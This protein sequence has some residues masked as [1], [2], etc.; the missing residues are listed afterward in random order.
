M[1]KKILLI[2]LMVMLFT[3]LFV[4]SASAET[5]TYRGEEIEL[6]DNLGDPSWYTGDVATAI[7]DKTSIV[8]LKD[9]EGN[10]TAYPSYYIFNYDISKSNNVITS[11]SIKSYENKGVDYSFINENG[12]NYTDGSVYYVE[13]PYGITNLSANGIFGKDADAKPEPNVVEI[14]MPDSVTKIESQAFRRM[15]SCQKITFSRN[16]TSLPD[17]GFCGSTQLSTLIFPE[18][19]QLKTIGNSFNGC[20]SITSFDFTTIPNIETLGSCFSSTKLAGPVDLS[21]LTKL[22]EITGTFQSC[23]IT[24]VTLPDN[25]QVIGDNAF[26]N[27]S[28]MYFASD[29]LPKS[30]I[31]IGTDNGGG[32]FLKNCK[33][34]NS[35][36]YFPESLTSI[37]SNYNFEGVNTANGAPLNLVFLGKMTEI[38]FDGGAMSGWTSGKITF[39]FAKNFASELE[40]KF[41]ESFEDENGQK[42]YICCKPDKTSL[43]TLKENTGLKILLAN[44]NP[45][46]ETTYGT[47]ADGNILKKISNS[48]P[49]FVFC[50]GEV[51]QEVFWAR[52]GSTTLEYTVFYST[53][54]EFD[55]AAHT[56]ANKH[57]N[58]IQYQP[59]NC[60]YDECTTTTCIV[61]K[62][63][64][65]IETENKATGEHT[66]EDDFN[67]ESALLCTTCKKELVAALTHINKITVA[68]ANGYTNNGKKISAC[69]NEG[70]N[71]CTE[72]EV[73]PIF[74]FLGF[75]IKMDE[76]EKGITF[77]YNVDNEALLAYEEH[78]G[79]LEFG[80]VMAFSAKLNGNEPIANGEAAQIAG[81]NI[82][83][84]KL[85]DSVV[86]NE[87]STIDFILRGANTLWDDET[88][89]VG[90]KTLK[91]APIV[92]AGY[93]IDKDNNVTYFDANNSSTSA[94][95]FVQSFNGILAK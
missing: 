55:M 7:Q 20:T 74:E 53:P 94:Q 52:N 22:K 49:S 64:S 63:T 90:D 78:Q 69:T 81:C 50:G 25:L 39:Y 58:L 33:K 32:H 38:R 23:P 31:R 6:I 66:Y 47:D 60:G 65:K 75:S 26:S 17:W 5:I 16:L 85:R 82:I 62:L 1:K 44:N 46:N 43:H 92:L 42:Y 3:C 70:C 37:K 84:P 18:G 19:N 21:S 95:G 4:I 93:T 88:V 76:T 86:E 30:L 61:C 35:T 2:S 8:I 45:N 34:I 48:S 27:C 79:R 11:V 72:I 67:C 40:G 9:A 51:V 77:G 56:T 15:N 14:V 41:V 29:Y 80:T 12:K 10:K 91:D 28:D 59:Q 54:Y 24:V 83:M 71:V 13:F 68:Y 87:V 36:L 89:L 57:Y 73:M